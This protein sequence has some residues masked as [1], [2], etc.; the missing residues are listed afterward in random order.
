MTVASS[1]FE[2]THQWMRL[3]LRTILR[4]TISADDY[5]TRAKPMNR[6]HDAKSAE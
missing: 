4:A 5:R 3:T 2:R 6:H 1:M